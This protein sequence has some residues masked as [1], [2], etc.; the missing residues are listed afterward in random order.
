MAATALSPLFFEVVCQRDAGTYEADCLNAGIKTS[1]SSLEE[2]HDNLMLAATRHYGEGVPFSPG[3][4]H[5]LMYE[6]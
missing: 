1:G 3:D 2:L 5:L 6:E 4:I